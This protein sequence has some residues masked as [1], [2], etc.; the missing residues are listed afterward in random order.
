[1]GDMFQVR[2]ASEIVIPA[3]LMESLVTK[4]D[5]GNGILVEA[6]LLKPETGVLSYDISG[7]RLKI[8]YD[9]EGE[10]RET[11]FRLGLGTVSEISV[12]ILTEILKS[13]HENVKYP[14]IKG[15]W[16]EWIKPLRP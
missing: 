11:V 1:M 12:M 3:E 5:S 14:S 13:F 9:Y 2:A 6:S 10:S 16:I 7:N 15:I 4:H 8:F